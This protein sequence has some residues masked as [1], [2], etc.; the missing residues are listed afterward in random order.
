MRL[1]SQGM[2]S[3]PNEKRVLKSRKNKAEKLHKP[4]DDVGGCFG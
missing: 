3:D 4:F 1:V 2:K